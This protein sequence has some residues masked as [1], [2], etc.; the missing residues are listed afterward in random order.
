MKLIS[1]LSKETNT[2]IHTIRYYENYGLFQGQKDAATP[3]NN[4]SYYGQEVSDKLAIIRDA[5]ALGFTLSE[6][7]ILIDAWYT[8]KLSIEERQQVLRSKITEIDKKI[9]QLREMKKRVAEMIS[10]VAKDE[11]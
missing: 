8:K 10:Y 6:I 7:K 9:A 11:C 1:Q 3:S 4:Y 2:P 5:K